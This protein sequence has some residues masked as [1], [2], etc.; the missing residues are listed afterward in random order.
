MS[1]GK[2]KNKIWG[3]TVRIETFLNKEEDIIISGE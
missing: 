2:G 1:G 3:G